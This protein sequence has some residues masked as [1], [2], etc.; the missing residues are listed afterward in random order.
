MLSPRSGARARRARPRSTGDVD[1]VHAGDGP[2]SN[3][4]ITG[5]FDGIRFVRPLP[6]VSVRVTL[7]ELSPFPATIDFVLDTGATATTIH[8]M[9]MLEH[10]RVLPTHLADPERWRRHTGGQGIGGR[11]LSFVERA[12]LAFEREDG[13]F[14]ALDE[15]IHVAQ[16]ADAS[17][18]LPSIL[19]WDVLRHFRLTLDA[20]TGLVRLEE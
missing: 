9:D 10:F 16:L 5:F 7:A 6:R 15:E 14:L 8:P 4:V 13:T 17:Q 3:V 18:G 19:G 1:R 20:R 11:V 2:L 12:D